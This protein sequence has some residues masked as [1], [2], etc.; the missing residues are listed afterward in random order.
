MFAG[1]GHIAPLYC[2]GLEGAAPG[3]LAQVIGL[4][5]SM[6]PET[7]FQ[8]SPAWYAPIRNVCKSGCF[9]D[10]VLQLDTVPTSSARAVGRKRRRV[11]ENSSSGTPK[12]AK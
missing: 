6:S 8:P 11:F 7:R 12:P 2:A 4:V 9:Q 1:M 10:A 3:P 5:V